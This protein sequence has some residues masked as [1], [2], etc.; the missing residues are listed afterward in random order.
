MVALVDQFGGAQNAVLP[1]HAGFFLARAVRFPD[2]D[3]GIRRGGG[4][5]ENCARS[6]GL[7]SGPKM[8]RRAREH[9]GAHD[10]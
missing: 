1:V 6:A 2:G 7:Q 9:L 10:A 5:I 3:R 8:R 4:E